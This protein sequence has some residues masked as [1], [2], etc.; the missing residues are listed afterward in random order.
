L[1]LSSRYGHCRCRRGQSGRGSGRSRGIVRPRLVLVSGVPGLRR[2]TARSGSSSA[3]SVVL[4]GFQPSPVQ[5]PGASLSSQD[6][7][8]T[9]GESRDKSHRRKYVKLQVWTNRDHDACADCL[10]GVVFSDGVGSRRCRGSARRACR[11]DPWRFTAGV[12]SLCASAAGWVQMRCRECA[13][14]VA[15][16]A[17]MCSRGVRPL[18]P[19]GVGASRT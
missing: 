12:V 14:E 15:V 5:V 4:T 8:L 9:S 2:W 18:D 3:S 11:D 1:G 10:V 16:T 7:N 17:R 6:R 19:A 13:A